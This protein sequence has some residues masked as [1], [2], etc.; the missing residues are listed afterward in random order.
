MIDGYGRVRIFRGFNDVQ[1]SKGTGYKPGGPDYLPKALVHEFVLDAFEEQGF[2]SFRIPMMWAATHPSE[3]TTDMAY[4]EATAKIIDSMAQHNM[5]ALLDMHQDVL[6]SS[7]GAYD[8]APR[9]L[10]ERTE[11]RHAYPW[12]ETLPLKAWGDGYLT[13]ATGQCFQDIYDNK[14]GGLD[15]WAKFWQDVASYFKSQPYILGYELINEPW[16]GDQFANPT[17]LIPGLAGQN[18]AKPYARLAEAIREKDNETAI[19]FEPVTYGMIMSGTVAGTGFKTAPDPNAVLAY[20]YYCWFTDGSNGSA[21]YPPLKRGECD[22]A[23]GPAVFS[24]I[25]EDKKTLK[26]PAMM[27]EWGNMGPKSSEADSTNTVEANRV[28]D[29]S[30]AHFTSWTMWDLVSI[31]PHNY[32]AAWGPEVYDILK[33]FAR[34]YAQAIAGTPSNMANE[35]VSKDGAMVGTKFQLDFTIGTQPLSCPICQCSSPTIWPASDC[36]ATCGA[37]CGSTCCCIAGVGA[38]PTSEPPVI[39]VITAP[40]EIVVPPLWFPNGF[41]VGLS[42]GL[43]W[44]M[45]PGRRNVVAVSIDAPDKAPTSGTVVILAKEQPPPQPSC[46]VCSCSSPSIWPVSGCDASCGARCGSKCCC[47]AGVGSCPNQL[48]IV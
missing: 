29:L 6:S 36:D 35:W 20:H 28:L 11:R 43:S 38:C 23:F 32:S 5:H 30:D 25:E 33:V 13:E 17:F 14:H 12:P 40:T 7:L 1:R 24:A 42:A 21:P 9:W 16:V 41:T 19:F 26:V 44:T 39:P 31:L 37:K 47:I 4:L 8:G 48:F 46:P 15:D 18:L 3:G 10:V 45:A 34:P 22:A 27:T 2:N